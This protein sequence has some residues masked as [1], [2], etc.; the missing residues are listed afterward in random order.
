MTIKFPQKG[1][2]DNKPTPKNLYKLITE[3]LK[4]TDVCLDKNKFNAAV[5]LWP[6]RAYCNPPFSNKEVFILRAAASNKAGSEVLLYLPFDPTTSWFRTLYQQNALIMVFMKRMMHA[7]F[8]HAL[9]HLKT[10]THTSS[11][12]AERIRYL[13]A[14]G[15]KVRK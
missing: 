8:P 10:H 15:S 12:A 2:Y 7:K 4:F 5:K 14:A 1:I 3:E 13:K 6:N 11:A 9:Y